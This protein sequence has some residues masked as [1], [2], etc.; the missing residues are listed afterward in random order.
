MRMGGPVQ[1]LAGLMVITACVQSL[2]VSTR[3]EDHLELLICIS[4]RSDYLNILMCVFFPYML[5][6]INARH[7]S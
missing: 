4:F 2:C 6:R 5:E 3:E 1:H 7:C